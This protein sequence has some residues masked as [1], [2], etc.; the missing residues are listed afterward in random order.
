MVGAPAFAAAGAEIHSATLVAVLQLMVVVIV[1][2]MVKKCASFGNLMPNWRSHGTRRRMARAP[3]NERD[4]V[5]P[6]WLV[7]HGWLR[8][9]QI[10]DQV[11]HHENSES[12]IPVDGI[13]ST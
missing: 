3:R 12:G 10:L 13:V 1:L 8:M 9:P 2:V 7:L 11:S 4:V 5:T 6:I